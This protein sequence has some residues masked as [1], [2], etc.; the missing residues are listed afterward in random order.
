MCCHCLF[1]SLPLMRFYTSQWLVPFAS[2][3]LLWGLFHIPGWGEI[4]T[5]RHHAGRFCLLYSVIFTCFYISCCIGLYKWLK[6]MYLS[7]SSF[8]WWLLKYHLKSFM[9]RQKFPGLFTH[10]V[11]FL[12]EKKTL[13]IKAFL[14]AQGTRKTKSNGQRLKPRWIQMRL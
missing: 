10:I 5:T 9:K 7:R 1:S 6:N 3:K 2:K 4:M 11:N 14:N 8:L 13:G 12:L